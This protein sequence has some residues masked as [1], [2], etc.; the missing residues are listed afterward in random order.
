M[1]ITCIMIGKT[2]E[3][4]LKYGIEK[5]TQRLSR[6]CT[7]SW[8]EIPDTARSKKI[9]ALEQKKK[10]AA[11]LSQKIPPQS[12]V[13]LLDEKGKDYTSEQFARHI[14]HQEINSTKELCF[15]IGGPYGFADSVY[16]QYPTKISLSKMTFSHQMIRVF[17]CE[18]IYRA[19]SI[20]YNLPYHHK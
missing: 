11:I 9:S 13:F 16:A 6:Y 4:Y 2:D 15:V 3:A 7:F 1:K 8:I 10:E 14:E 17:L 19:Y 20:I 12:T 5:Y 18:Q